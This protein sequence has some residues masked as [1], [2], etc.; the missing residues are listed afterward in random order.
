MTTYSC[1]PAFLA[2]PAFIFANAFGSICTFFGATDAC[3]PDFILISIAGSMD[4]FFC[5]VVLLDFGRGLTVPSGVL[6]AGTG[7]FTADCAGA[8]TTEMLSPG[9]TVDVELNVLGF[10]G[11]FNVEAPAG[12][13]AAGLL[14]VAFVTGAALIALLVATGLAFGL[15]GTVVAAFLAAGSFCT[16]S[17]GF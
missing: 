1:H 14:G 3:F 11:R 15:S 16:N 4:T 13:R 6:F 10:N 12:I 9:W 8:F 7:F 17:P 2:A 5:D